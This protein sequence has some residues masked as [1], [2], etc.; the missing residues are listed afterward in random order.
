LTFIKQFDFEVVHRAGARHGNADGLSRRPDTDAHQGAPTAVRG[1]AVEQTA[2]DADAPDP[3]KVKRQVSSSA[4]EHPDA[5]EF[6]LAERNK[7]TYDM[8][9][10]TQKYKVGDWVYYFNPRKFAGRQDKWRRKFSGPFLVTKIIG[11]VNVMVQR[12]K[13]TRPCTHI[14]KL[15]PFIADEMPR[16]WLQDGADESAHPDRDAPLANTDN[17]SVAFDPSVD[18]EPGNNAEDAPQNATEQVNDATV[19]DGIDAHDGAIIGAPPVNFRMPRPSRHAQRP[20]R[21]L[22]I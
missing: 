20:R 12:I 7:R 3:N 11:P 10:R 6:T 22:D 14:D 17:V 2:N 9:V 18:A 15:K 19:G 4:G 13:R 21:Y 16:S 1:V 8:R 5:A